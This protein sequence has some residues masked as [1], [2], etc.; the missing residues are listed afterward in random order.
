MSTAEKEDTT[1]EPH[2]QRKNRVQLDHALFDVDF[3]DKPKIRSME[4]KFGPLATLLIARLICDLS[5]ATNAEIDDECLQF[6]AKHIGFEKHNEFLDYCIDRG[7]LIRS[8]LNSISNSRVAEDQEKL[9]SKQEKWRNAKRISTDSGEN[10]KGSLKDSDNFPPLHG[11]EELNTEELNTEERSNTKEV[12]R[13]GVQ[14][15]T[16]FV[17]TGKTLRAPGVWISD[18]E[19]EW[20]VLEYSR[21]DLNKAWADRGLIHTARHLS[22]P[23]NSGKNGY[24]HWVSWAL[25][26][27]LNDKKA[28]LDAKTAKTRNE[29]ANKNPKSESRPLPQVV[30]PRA[31]LPDSLDDLIS[32]AIPAA[33]FAAG[34]KC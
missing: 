22:Q 17:E 32:G 34:R 23:K 3:F 15:E 7:I 16:N 31:V 28:G 29:N 5:R 4:V 21:A 14:G 10:L 18:I 8:A 26:E 30:N 27:C 20:G 25:R 33:T 11:C 24:V 9:A 1:Q 6:H 12:T 2:C 13:K 19:Y